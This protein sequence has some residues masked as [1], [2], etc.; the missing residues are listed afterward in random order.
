MHNPQACVC[1]QGLPQVLI[2][3]LVSFVPSNNTDQALVSAA[4]KGYVE[5]GLAK[6]CGM[7]LLEQPKDFRYLGQH[8]FPVCLP[9][10]LQFVEADME[11]FTQR[12]EPD[13]INE[14]L[15]LSPYLDMLGKRSL[16]SQ[17]SNYYE[18]HWTLQT[19]IK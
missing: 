12:C 14:M 5:I 8:A 1:A 15:D 19:D 7:Q 3:L 13:I 6:L 11:R 2:N 4:C 10:F 9:P 18:K 17:V 16:L